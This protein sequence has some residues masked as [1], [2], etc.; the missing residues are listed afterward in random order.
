M[1]VLNVYG[2]RKSRKTLG[3]V[4]EIVEQGTEPWF[5]F[6]MRIFLISLKCLVSL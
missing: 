6:E 2:G 1:I 5:R 3:R 4:A